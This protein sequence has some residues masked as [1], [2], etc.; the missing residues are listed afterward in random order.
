[1]AGGSITLAQIRPILEA[2]VREIH[3]GSAAC[4]GGVVDAGLVRRIVEA[5]SMR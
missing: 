3:L 2:G 5:A 1:M 4:S